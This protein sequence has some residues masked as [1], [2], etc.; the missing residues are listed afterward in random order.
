MLIWPDR[1]VLQR[2]SSARCRLAEF[3]QTAVDGPQQAAQLQGLAEWSR[4]IW[5]VAPAVAS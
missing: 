1:S 5:S 4:R 2:V 3:A